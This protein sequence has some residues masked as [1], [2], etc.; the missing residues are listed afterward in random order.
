[1]KKNVL[2]IVVLALVVLVAS[3]YKNEP[4]G[5]RGHTWGTA[6]PEG[7]GPVVHTDPSYGGIDYYEAPQEDLKLGCAQLVSVRYGFWQGK[8]FDAM[9]VFE[10]YTN[11]SCVKGALTEKFGNGFQPNEFIEKYLWFGK[12]TTI[13]LKYNEISKLGSM[14]MS[15]K[16]ISNQQEVWEKA[17]AKKG[18][19]DGF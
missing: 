9:V 6:V 3:A 16:V 7:W 1:M 8:L 13:F 19:T 2:A 18:A 4:P 14:S 10:G 12:V 5:F 15:S 17:Q 11:F